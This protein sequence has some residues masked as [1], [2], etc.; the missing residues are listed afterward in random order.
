MD[1]HTA[2]CTEMEIILPRR[3]GILL[4]Q[5]RQRHELRGAV[6]LARRLDIS[7]T[8]L[9]QVESGGRRPSPAI[10]RPEAVALVGQKPTPQED[11]L[12]S[13]LYTFRPTMRRLAYAVAQRVPASASLRPVWD[14][15]WQCDVDNLDVLSNRVQQLEDGHLVDWLIATTHRIA[16]HFDTGELHAHLRGPLASMPSVYVSTSFSP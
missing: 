1:I 3:W 14:D 4:R 5:A 13:L 12:W 10:V 7:A 9:L 2:S 15:V 11:A 6:H 16:F 8:L